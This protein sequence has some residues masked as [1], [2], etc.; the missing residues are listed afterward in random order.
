M[1]TRYYEIDI[2]FQETGKGQAELIAPKLLADKEWGFVQLHEG[3]QK[4]IVQIEADVEEHKSIVADKA[5]R[6]LT[7]KQLAPLKKSYPVPRS[8]QRYHPVEM[9]TG[10]SPEEIGRD[11]TIE[12]VQQVRWKFYV[13]DVQI[14][15]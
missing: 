12:T 10:V 8:K 14:Q 3:E 6:S 7:N 15:T 9:Q 5:F 13:I 4:A 11:H 1:P 2:Q